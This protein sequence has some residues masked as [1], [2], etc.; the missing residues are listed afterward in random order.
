MVRIST[1]NEG[2]WSQF[3]HVQNFPVKVMDESRL[4]GTDYLYWVETEDC[5]S[6]DGH[7]EAEESSICRI[8][9]DKRSWAAYFE[10]ET[11]AY[12]RIRPVWEGFQAVGE[13]REYT[14]DEVKSISDENKVVVDYAGTPKEWVAPGDFTNVKPRITIIW[15]E[16]VRLTW[17]L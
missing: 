13:T 17:G 6:I 10:R 12:V 2:N 15:T 14:L 4:E 1:H 8:L 9:Y 11:W 5:V 3:D 7:S 16:V